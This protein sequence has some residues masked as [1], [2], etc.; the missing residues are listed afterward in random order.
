MIV[1]ENN[2][3]WVLVLSECSGLQVKVIS[4]NVPESLMVPS[5]NCCPDTKILYRSDSLRHIKEQ[6][7]SCLCQILKA[8]II[9][10][11]CR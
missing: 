2:S 9:L 7:V 10:Y 4:E 3:V 1:K 5:E 11:P 6:Q 8:D